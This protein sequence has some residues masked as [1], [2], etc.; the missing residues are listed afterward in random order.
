[1]YR[2]TEAFCH[3]LWNSPEEA[4]ILGSLTFQYL[5]KKNGKIWKTEEMR[6]K[7]IENMEKKLS[8]KNDPNRRGVSFN[9][10]ATSRGT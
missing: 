8:D 4:K 7:N 2:Y 10:A 3:Y 1:M 9:V 6:E 5:G